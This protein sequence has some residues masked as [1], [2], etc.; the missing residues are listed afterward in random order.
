M[1][2]KYCCLCPPITELRS[3]LLQSPPRNFGVLQLLSYRISGLICLI[4]YTHIL[5]R[6]DSKFGIVFTDCCPHLTVLEKYWFTVTDKDTWIALCTKHKLY[7]YNLYRYT[8]GE[9]T[10][11]IGLCSVTATKSIRMTGLNVLLQITFQ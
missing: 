4:V 10:F 1:S 3:R 11:N 5:V 7:I 2:N 6:C 9:S 8:H